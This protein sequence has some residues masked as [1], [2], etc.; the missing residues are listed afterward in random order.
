[1]ML[2]HRGALG[3]REARTQGAVVAALRARP[4]TTHGAVQGGPAAEVS[5]PSSLVERA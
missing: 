1:M 2:R 4:R 3:M 5:L